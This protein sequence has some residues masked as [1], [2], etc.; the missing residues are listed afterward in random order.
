MAGLHTRIDM[1]F[2]D[3]HRKFLSNGHCL[4][5]SNCN[6]QKTVSRNLI[7]VNAISIVFEIAGITVRMVCKMT[8][9]NNYRF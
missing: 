5:S 4:K 6:E 3:V 8:F 9:D 7:F 2:I 1:T